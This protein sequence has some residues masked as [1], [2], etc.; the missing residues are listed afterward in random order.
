M[1]NNVRS[2]LY[3]AVKEI[4][5]ILSKLSKIAMD[6]EFEY[7]GTVYVDKQRIADVESD[8]ISDAIDSIGIGTEKLELLLEKGIHEDILDE[9]EF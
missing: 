7:E 3:R 8:I 6:V 1:N 2:D 9:T 5:D 4:K